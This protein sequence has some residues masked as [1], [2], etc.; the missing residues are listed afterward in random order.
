MHLDLRL[1]TFVGRFDLGRILLSNGKDR[2]AADVV[3]APNR[4]N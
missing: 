2:V 4:F 1:D 3:F